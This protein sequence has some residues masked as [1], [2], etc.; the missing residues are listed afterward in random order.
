MNRKT[1]CVVLVVL[2]LV[3]FNTSTLSAQSVANTYWATSEGGEEDRA[4][5]V[6]QFVVLAFE[7]QRI[8]HYWIWYGTTPNG[9][10][11]ISLGAQFGQ[12]GPHNQAQTGWQGT[13]T[14][15]GNTVTDSGGYTYTISGDTITFGGYT[16]MRVPSLDV[17]QWPPRVR[18]QR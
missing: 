13:Y 14:Q 2:V 7:E 17:N 3:A 11:L 12:C 6:L 1:V 9:R 18:D 10:Q 8:T 15:S 16:Y 4:A 5:G